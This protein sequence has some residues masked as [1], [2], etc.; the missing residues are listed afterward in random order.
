M[1]YV[2]EETT[3]LDAKHLN[4]VH[5][6]LEKLNIATD[7]INKLEMQ[8]DAARTKF[9]EIQTFWSQKLNDLSKKYGTAIAKGRPYYEAKLEERR[10]RE[11]AQ[12]A[13]IRFER[14]NSM[15]A[16]AKQQVNLTQDSLNRQK[17]FEPEC[18][19]VLN[20]HIQR[21][22]EAEKE[23]VA[24]EEAH[25]AISL[26]MAECTA[27]IAIMQKENGRAIKKSRHYFEQRVQ[28]TKVLENQKRLIV[29]LETEVRQKKFDYTTSL[30][31]LEQ[32][33]DSIHQERSLSGIKPGVNLYR[34][35]SKVIK[36]NRRMEQ[37]SE[38]NRRKFDNIEAVKG[39]KSKLDEMTLDC[40]KTI[41]PAIFDEEPSTSVLDGREI[42]SSNLGSGVILLAQ[43]LMGNSDRK[44]GTSN[45][46]LN[47]FTAVSAFSINSELSDFRYHTE[48]P[49]GVGTCSTLSSPEVSDSESSLA[50][51]RTG[52]TN[53][54]EN[55]SGMLRSHSM[56]IEVSSFCDIDECA[57]RTESL[58]RS[59]SDVERESSSGDSFLY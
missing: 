25:R 42:R 11:E 59:V 29:E 6:E 19:E 49:D 38:C 45:F 56:L 10:L 33:S 47:L 14:A 44:R 37:E 8:L 24:A 35:D 39:I 20:H 46:I 1:D 17:T 55:L 3:V 51:S 27:R 22:N 34:K 50:S 48:L 30:R 32:I 23:R 31:N 2:E 9:R 40:D 57:Q 15:H 41:D 58:L 36:D 43:H 52:T 54:T 12:N 4:R 7:V 21:V 53:T 5:E 16:V 13:A 28:F 18:L 26:K